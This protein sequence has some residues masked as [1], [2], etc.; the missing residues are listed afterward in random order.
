MTTVTQIPLTVTCC[1]PID[2]DTLDRETAEALAGRIKA[3]ADPARLQ[4]LS[5]IAAAGEACA[6]DLTDPLDLSQPTVSHHLKVLTA[7]GFLHREQ[8]G[9]WAFFSVIPDQLHAVA[10]AIEPA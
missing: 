3:L 6:C 1:P 5:L 9:K 10:N 2:G 4:L 8:R 7:A